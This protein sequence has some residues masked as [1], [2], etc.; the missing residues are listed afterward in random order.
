[1]AKTT[2]AE[3]A[4]S[5]WGAPLLRLDRSWT[6]LEQ[7]LAV[8]VIL[9]EIVVLCFSVS[10]SGLSS[11]YTPGGNVA[12]LIFRSILSSIGLGLV[13]HFAMRPRSDA[14][15]ARVRMHAFAVTGAAVLGLFLGRL[16]PNG[17]QEY[18]TNMRA[19]IQ[20]AS[21]IMLIGGLRGL[22]TR[23]TLWL[24]LLGA[25]IATSKG[26]HINI[27]VATRYLP[28]KAVMPIA[29]VGWLAA[30]A[31][32]FAA[33]WAFVAGIAVTKFNADA[34]RSCGGGKL[35]DTPVGE[36]L[37]TAQKGMA[38]DLFLL[39]RQISLDVSTFPRVLAGK[40]YD[41]SGAAWNAW[42][43]ESYDGWTKHF[44]K[45][46]VDALMVGPE[47]VA[48]PRMPAVSAPGGAAA[49]GLLVRDLNFILPFGLLV[50]GI[51]FVLRVLLVLSRQVSFDPDSAHGD[52]EENP[53][54]VHGPADAD[55]TGGAS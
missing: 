41:M 20:N 31:V 28:K 4:P 36:R 43:K 5:P 30:A 45:E 37:A 47:A 12:G 19:W 14:P 15:E 38:S 6:R 18:A 34:F 9:T 21:A 55:A 23:L 3:A 32:C 53:H 48:N 35:C 44:P 49:Q 22:V 13:V 46:G 17:G 33:C 16:W 1:M 39:G 24:A 25:S 10:L 54:L 40:S 51:K 7:G 11:F 42:L 26:K 50:I 52:E 8:V 27:D 2:E 29:V